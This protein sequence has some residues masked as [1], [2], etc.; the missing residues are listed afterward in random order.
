M[1]DNITQLIAMTW[2]HMITGLDTSVDMA[3]ML[4]TSGPTLIVALML[5]TGIATILTN[6]SES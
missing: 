2:H 6:R 1:I 3:F 4:V 5:I